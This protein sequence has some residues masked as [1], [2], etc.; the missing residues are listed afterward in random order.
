MEQKP[1]EKPWV[2]ELDWPGAVSTWRMYTRNGFTGW[3]KVKCTFGQWRTRWLL[4]R[5][6]RLTFRKRG[7]SGL[8]LVHWSSDLLHAMLDLRRVA[9]WP[10][11]DHYGA[12]WGWWN[13]TCGRL[14]RFVARHRGDW[15]LAKLQLVQ[16]Q[17]WVE[18]MEA[19]NG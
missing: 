19:G 5:V 6:A 14:R 15:L 4:A 13:Y 10:W 17:V 12:S 18:K 11:A 3:F 16:Q 2:E 8:E 9:E 7:R 1:W